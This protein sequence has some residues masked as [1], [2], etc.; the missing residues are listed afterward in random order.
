MSYLVLVR[1]GKSE[2][3]ALG[4]W[5]GWTDI[6]LNEEGRAEARSAGLAI[7]DIHLDIAFTSKLIRAQQTLD[8]IKSAL[9]LLNL[10]TT[11]DEALNERNYGD[12]TG[13][14]KWE[15][16]KMVGDQEFQKIRRAWDYR[17]PNGESLKDVYE[18]VVPYFKTTILPELLS[19]KNAIITAHGNSSRALVKYLENVS[20]ESI[21][22]LE[23]GTGEV[24][25]YQIDKDGKIVSK[26]IRAS[27]PLAGKV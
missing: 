19:G 23:I 1:H 16:K 25:I 3:N 9:N 13:K 20:D 12:Y 26:E 17:L 8:E 2:W 10:P 22:K 15:I 5:T 27:N 21:P 24:Y 11:E 7:K 18:R 14:N 4:K 6:P